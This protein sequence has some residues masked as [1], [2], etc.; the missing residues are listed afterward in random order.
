VAAATPQLRR[1]TSALRAKPAAPP[2][3]SDVLLAYAVMFGWGMGLSR[4]LFHLPFVVADPQSAPHFGLGVPSYVDYVTLFFEAIS[5][6]ILAPLVEELVFR[7]FLQNLWIA[8]H[9]TWRGLLLASLAFGIVHRTQAPFAFVI[10]IVLGLVY[11]KY[12]SLVLCMLLHGLY[13]L[14]SRFSPLHV[15][16]LE[17]PASEVASLAAWVPE[18]AVTIA[19]IPVAMLFWRRF[20]PNAVPAAHAPGSP[21]SP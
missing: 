9:G 19:L 8:R 10:G 17:K 11:I 3:L 2:S 14:T 18:I 21:G 4:L 12:R 15:P 13:N 7:G 5:A 1:M 20:K 16:F 6:G